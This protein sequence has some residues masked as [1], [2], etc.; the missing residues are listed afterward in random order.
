MVREAPALGGAGGHLVVCD[1]R[2]GHE[3]TARQAR[4]PTTRR[5]HAL[6]G[7]QSER[8]SAMWTSTGGRAL[9]EQVA[10]D[11]VRERGWRLRRPESAATAVTPATPFACSAALALPPAAQS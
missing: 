9:G 7:T 10:R 11:C 8:A 4:Q 2:P 1:L 3:A 5:L 6:T